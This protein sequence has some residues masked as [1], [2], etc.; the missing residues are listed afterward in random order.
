MFVLNKAIKLFTQ[1]KKDD[2]TGFIHNNIG[3]MYLRNQNKKNLVFENA[4]RNG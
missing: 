3:V 4:F 1:N 2:E